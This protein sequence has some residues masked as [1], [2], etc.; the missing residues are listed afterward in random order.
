MNQSIANHLHD[1]V[2]QSNKN[3]RHDIH[4]RHKLRHV[5]KK[6]QFFESECIDSEGSEPESE[7]EPVLRDKS[8]TLKDSD[9][10]SVQA[11]QA[12]KNKFAKS[13]RLGKRNRIIDEIEDR[14]R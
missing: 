4:S 1:F 6:N 11:I 9:D 12:R 13:K 8:F 10:D 5:K 7:E 2:L 14:M 3:G